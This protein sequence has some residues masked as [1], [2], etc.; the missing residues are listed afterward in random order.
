FFDALL[1]TTGLRRTRLFVI[2][3]N[4]DVDR[5]LVSD[6]AKAISKSLSDLD[7]TNTLLK[8]P[9]D[10]HLIMARFKGYADWFN[11]FFAPKLSFD[12]E[13]YFYVRKIK[14]EGK[15]IALLGLNSAWL[16]A[17]DQ[18][19]AEGLL[20]GERQARAALEQ[21]QGADL[22]IALL[23]HPFDWLRDFDQDDSAALLHKGCDF[24]LHGHLHKNYATRLT[25][26]DSTAM[27]LACG[28]CYETRDFPNMVSWVQLDLAAGSG[29]V[30]LRRYSAAQGGFWAEDHLTYKN[31]PGKYALTAWRQSTSQS[32]TP[33][34]TSPTTNSSMAVED[35][36]AINRLVLKRYNKLSFQFIRS[37]RDKGATEADIENVFVPLRM[38]NPDAMASPTWLIPPTEYRQSPRADISH[39]ATLPSLLR[40]YQCLLLRGQTG[41]GK[42]TLLRYIALSF[43]G[44]KYQENLEWSGPPLLPLL[45]SLRNFG[46]FLKRDAGHW[47]EPQ[48][49]ALLAY[50]KYHL[51][52]AN[53]H[54]PLH[55]L[56]QWLEKGKCCLLLDAL[57]EVT[58]TLGDG[59]DLRIEVARQVSA[60]IRNYMPDGNLFILSSRPHAYRD[61]SLIRW[62]LPEPRVCD[63]LD[64]EPEDSQDLIT[65]L[66]T[67]LTGGK[68]TSVL[69]TDRLLTAIT[70]D[71]LPPL[72]NNP[73][74][75]TILA[76]TPLADRRAGDLDEIV[77]L[78]SGRWEYEKRELYHPEELSPWN[79]LSPS[80][81]QTIKFQRRALA[82]LAWHMHRARISEIQ[83]E[84]AIK[85]LAKFYRAETHVDQASAIEWACAFL[86]LTYERSGL[87]IAV[88][89][90]SYTFAHQAFREYMAATYLVNLGEERLTKEILRHAPHP[91]GWWEQVILLAGAH[92]QLADQAAGRLIETLLEQDDV[93]H[94]HLAAHCA[95]EMA[96]KLP[97]S[98]REK[99]R[100]WLTVA[101]QDDKRP[102]QERIQAGRALG[103]AGDPRRGITLLPLDSEEVRQRLSLPDILWADIPSGTLEMGSPEGETFCTPRGQQDAP[104][105]NEYWRD[106]EAHII[107]PQLCKL[108]TYA[109]SAYPITVAQ[110]QPFIQ[111]PEGWAK[112]QWWTKD[113]LAYRRNK[114]TPPLWNDPKWGID[115]HPVVGITWYA[116]VAYCRW[117]TWRLQTSG[118]IKQESLVRLPTETE[119]EW[120]ARGPESHHWPWG[121]DWRPGACNSAEIY[122][123][124]KKD[125]TPIRAEIDPDQENETGGR[126]SAVGMFHSGVNWTGTVYD[127]AGNVREWCTTKGQDYS[128]Y[129]PSL[130]GQDEWANDYLAG[131]VARVI[132]GGSFDLFA[133]FVRGAARTWGD[134]DHG[135]WT[136]GFRCVLAC[137]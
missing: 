45:I 1:K 82:T 91:D 130:T 68:E 14:V 110:F 128:D 54:L 102:G 55:G 13:R 51:E 126:T 109:L 133:R 15:Q 131:N 74:V 12:D 122:V 101:M 105:E 6:G 3:G 35:I 98:Q 66:L 8:T 71:H 52:G 106:E 26:P 41:C 60:F 117:L 86:K 67:A 23:H 38:T 39:L 87:F 85:T 63:I 129:Y 53:V 47:A 48:P 30:Y 92:P 4:H 43:A 137:T 57:D 84:M 61:D 11:T 95:R 77:T 83:S 22:K 93:A 10:R 124:F 107:Q 49:C 36:T 29:T 99:L 59:S 78:L 136:Q 76:L 121:N 31:A 116:A 25:T 32:G 112:D 70:H 96:D 42:S 65:S 89:D 113:G 27:V 118:K 16:C 104:D 58:G 115:N 37:H 46:V 80:P 50:L 79:I 9:L 20:I 34:S 125:G 69:E 120:A 18:D 103:I 119:W 5:N 28:A 72:T 97:G 114:K 132:R 134:P 21:A 108:P 127:M 19:K 44:G 62:A 88:K 81:G 40:K 73:L 100:D 2:P 94:A 33:S 123:A 75:C 56:E 135:E 90:D 7:S 17:S 111:D 64:L 24:I